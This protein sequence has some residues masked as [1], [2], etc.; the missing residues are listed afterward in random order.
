MRQWHEFMF[1]C[2]NRKSGREEGE[3]EELDLCTVKTGA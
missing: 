3:F 1:I 2:D